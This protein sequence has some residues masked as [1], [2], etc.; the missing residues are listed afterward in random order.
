MRINNTSCLAV[1]LAFVYAIPWP[2]LCNSA[3]SGS[4]PL[5]GLAKDQVNSFQT[6]RAKFLQVKD[7]SDG[8]GPA[9]NGPSCASCHNQPTIGGVGNVA[10]LRVGVVKDGRYEAPPGGDIVHLFSIADHACQP[11]IP[12][13]A[14][15]LARRIPTPLYGAGLIEAIPDSVI[16]TW[17]DPTDQNGDG[18]RG[19]AALV[20]DP[21]THTMRVGRFGWKAQQATLLAF[22]GEAFR[23]E[24]GITNDLFPN[25]VGTGLSAEQLAA[26]DT[27]ADPEDKPDPQSHLRGIDHFTNFMRFLAPVP[28]LPQNDTIHR[29]SEIF[30]SIGCAACHVPALLTGSNEILALDHK[31]VN[32]YSD[33]LL[34]DVGTGDGVEQG[35]AK[36]NE[37]RTSPLWGLRFRKRLMHDGNALNPADAIKQHHGESDRS[38]QT[39]DRLDTHQRQAL[40]DFLSSL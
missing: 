28:P 25:E 34:H 18:I 22:A 38:R 32:A 40:L 9:Y 13:D 17:E 5:S 15:N 7:A 2:L 29:G 37:F 20:M 39:F 12:A 26:C 30:S 24:M 4:L 10:V 33:F 35:G 16:R 19:R 36:G 1:A 23:N 31:V 11:H 6:G 8:L 3:N 27:V 21:V 14:N